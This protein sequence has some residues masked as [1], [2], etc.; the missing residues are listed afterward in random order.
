VFNTVVLPDG[1][2]APERRFTMTWLDWTVSVL[3][4]AVP[5]SVGVWLVATA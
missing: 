2:D 1:A 5:F 4:I 3:A